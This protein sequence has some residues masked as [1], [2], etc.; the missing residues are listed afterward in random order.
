MREIKFRVWDYGSDPKKNLDV[1]GKMEKV[2]HLT[3]DKN[4]IDQVKYGNAHF[5]ILTKNGSAMGWQLSP[6]VD[7]V[8]VVGNVYANPDL[9]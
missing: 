1:K 2:D 3:W 9:L 7:E 8:E 6:E 5:F 4:S